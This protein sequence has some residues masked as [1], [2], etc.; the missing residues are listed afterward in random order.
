VKRET[1]LLI[2][3]GGAAL[4]FLIYAIGPDTFLHACLHLFDTLDALF[5]QLA[6]MLGAQ[7]YSVIRAL[8]IAFYLVF[9][10][11]TLL[12]S[13]RRLAGIGMLVV[14]TI[15]IMLLVW[16]PFYEPAP[17]SHWLVTL[18]LVLAGAVTMTQRLMGPPR[19]IVPPAP[20]RGF[21]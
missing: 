1:L 20:P 15:I 10:V 17:I 4:A 18:A 12:A 6:E 19:S 3:I 11:L 14:M 7:A 13:R 9:V 8:A 16:R 2:W 5:R 21:P